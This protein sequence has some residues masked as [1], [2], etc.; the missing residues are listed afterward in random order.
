TFEINLV[1]RIVFGRRTIAQ[2][3]DHTAALG[4]RPLVVYNGSDIHVKHL[5][6]HGVAGSTW[7]QRGAPT[8]TDVDTAVQQAKDA[9]CDCVIGIGGGSAIDCAK[10]VAGLLTN[11][12]SARDYMEVVGDGKSITRSAAPWIAIPT[13]AGTGAEATRNAVVGLPEKQ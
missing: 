12:G 4:S 11:G 10:A 8:A 9:A 5:A 13:T 1:P 3:K 6:S 2:V 7:R